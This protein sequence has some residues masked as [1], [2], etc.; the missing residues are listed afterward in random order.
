MA[1]SIPK[2]NSEV[3]KNRISRVRDHLEEHQASLALFFSAKTIYYLTGFWHI[4][5]ERPIAVLVPREEEPIAFLPQLE[6]THW[7][8]DVP[9]IPEIASY[10][11]YP[12][13]KHPMKILAATLEARVKGDKR[14][15]ADSK[16]APSYWGYEGPLLSDLL[17]DWKFLDF[18]SLIPTMRIIKERLEIEFIKISAKWGA[19]AHHILQDESAA[20][21]TEWEI[22]TKA[23][24]VASKE[25]LEAMPETPTSTL[26]AY[27]GFR[28]QIGAGSALPHATFSNAV[29]SKGDVLV[30][31]ASADISHYHSELERTMIVGEPSQKQSR[32]FE[33]MVD[34]QS[35]AIA[36]IKPGNTC[37]DVDKA[38][39]GIFKEN[40]FG[41]LIAHHT[42][43]GIG[44]EG[45]ES[46]F[47]DRGL[48]TALKPGMVLTVEPG[49][50]ELGF[51]GFRHSDTVLVTTDGNEIL[52]KYPRELEDL[53]VG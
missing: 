19:R 39:A 32:Y 2:L 47:L 22:A 8:Q 48:E 9:W 35:A 31:G 40:G 27:A 6:I 34:A 50:Y 17:S 7:E 53:I 16:G 3:F 12:D 26:A 33:A 52:T 37:A 44:L 45:H 28:G 10:F 25:L 29:L 24:T 21:K 42:G 30:T 14:I 1:G 5:T 43:H 13:T 4:P 20:G 46:P 49:I 18:K 38:S 23:I 41:H 51:G 15:G 36:A 11:E